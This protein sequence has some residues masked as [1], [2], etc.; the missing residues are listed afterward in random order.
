MTNQEEIMYI[1]R[2]IKKPVKKTTHENIINK[3]FLPKSK[4]L[5]FG[6]YE[7][8]TCDSIP[9]GKYY[10]EIRYIEHAT[11]RKGDPAIIVY[12]IMMNFAE[13]YRRINGLDDSSKKLKK[14]KIKQV[15][16]L[17]SQAYCNFSEAMYDALDLSYD[18]EIDINKLIGIQE[19]LTIYYDKYS[20][21]GGIKSRCPWDEDCFVELY[22]KNNIDNPP[23]DS[24]NDVEY[25]E[26]DNII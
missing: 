7:L 9:A 17:D 22:N 4:K 8:P 20:D 2:N 11:T 24:Y 3:Q 10:S 25:D 5:G 18:E 6:D 26:Y 19:A 13:A 15:Y 16:P 23:I 1:K 12:F 21:I 14:H